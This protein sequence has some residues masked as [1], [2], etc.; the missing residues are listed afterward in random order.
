[1]TKPY[2]HLKLSETPSTIAKYFTNFILTINILTIIILSHIINF[3][4]PIYIIPI[5]FLLCY[6]SSSKIERVYSSGIDFL[7]NYLSEKTDNNLKSVKIFFRK[8]NFLNEAFD[9]FIL[10]FFFAITLL[11]SYLTNSVILAFLGFFCF[12]CLTTTQSKKYSKNFK[13]ADEA[14]EYLQNMKFLK[15]V[16]G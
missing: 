8:Y 7:I 6:W 1:M 13:N 5:L 10:N 2:L 15:K 4:A 9:L 11:P 14:K 12:I 16:S 3:N